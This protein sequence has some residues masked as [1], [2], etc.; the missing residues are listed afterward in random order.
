MSPSK[1]RRHHGAPDD[2]W[3]TVSGQPISTSGVY[4]ILKRIGNR[5]GVER[6]NSHAFRHALA[7]RLV[8]NGTP[9]KVIQDIMGHA[10]IT[11]TLSMYVE[12][13]DDELAEYHQHYN[14][15]D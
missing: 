13:N 11:T 3:L 4:Q 2:L 8:N 14:G 9:H 5:A 6:F 15:Y 10:D 12:Y 1:N 7:K